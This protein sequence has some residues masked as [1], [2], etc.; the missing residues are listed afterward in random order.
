MINYAKG[1]A[2]GVLCVLMFALGVFFDIYFSK[3]KNVPQNP[4]KSGF[5]F[6]VE[7]QSATTLLP[8]SFVSY[9]KF[10]ASKFLSTKVALSAE[11][12]GIISNAFNEIIARVG[13]EKLCVGGS[14]T[15]EPTFSYKDGLETPK[16]Q[17][18]QASLSCKIKK[19]ELEKYNDLMNDI[20][21]IATKSGLITVS[22]PALRASFS[23]ESLREN[24]DKLR[25]MLIKSALQKVGEY[26]NTTQKACELTSLDFARGFVG[27]R[28]MSAKAESNADASFDTALPVIDEEERT[29]N[30]VATYLCK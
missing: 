28:L 17:R 26:S 23:S 8:D 18:V 20:N 19:A 1:L 22:M 6:S 2:L 27:A 4:T 30:A 9:P 10:S 21:D 24:D 16:G 29:M 7:L 13:T 15:I 25:E 5:S 11:E 12:K 3:N 14:Y